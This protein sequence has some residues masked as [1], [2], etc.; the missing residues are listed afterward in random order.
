MTHI[1]KSALFKKYILS[2][3]LVF[4]LPLIVL[5]FAINFVYISSVREEL[6]LSNENYLEQSN[7]LLS[8][9][10]VEVKTLGNYIN[11][12][13]TF[14][15]FSSVMSENFNDY[16]ELIRHHEHSAS[17]I[18]ALYIVLDQSSYV[19]SSRG[20][21]TVPAML[22]H[23]IHFSNIEDMNKMYNMLDNSQESLFLL[24]DRLFYKMPLGT[25]PKAIGS[26]L[27]VMN[28][29]SIRSN[30]EM[31]YDRNE[32]MSFL[33]NNEGDIVLSSS[34]YPK[35]DQTSI[36]ANIPDLKEPG[37]MK[38]GRTDYLT[39]RVSNDLTGWSFISLIDSS[40]FYRPLYKALLLVILG[41]I[42]LTVFGL[43]ISYY[44]ANRNY[45]PVHKLVNAFDKEKKE[46][47]D[48]WGFL[49]QHISKT[50]TEVEAL[51]SLMDEQAPII[52]NA[53]LLDLL[54]GDFSSEHICEQRLLDSDIH[55]TYDYFST[56]I[57]EFGKSSAIP[58]Q[59][60]TVEKIARE[61]NNQLS[62][63]KYILEA[64]IP[65]LSNNQ[66]LLIVNLKN[67]NKL[68]WN[69]LIGEIR[70]YLSS[71]GFGEETVVKL[72]VG[73]TYSSYLKIRNSF[74]E[75][76][77][78]LEEL[79]KKRVKRTEILFF[80]DINR[81]EP[82]STV[83]RV[84]DY[85]KEMTLLLLQS[86]K[87]GNTKIAVE[88]IVELFSQ[89]RQKYSN[90][91][92]L[93]A[94]VSYVY[95]QVME[96]GNELNISKHNHLLFNL[97][98]FHDLDQAQEVLTQISHMLCEMVQEKKEYESNEIGNRI[99][100]HIFDEFLSPEIS[101]E[102]IAS[103][104]NISISYA[105]KIIKEETGDSFSNIIQSLRMNKFK[106]LLVTTT[107]PIKD[108]VVEVG[109]YDVS[110]FTRKFRKEH[111]LTPGQYRKKF[112]KTDLTAPA[113]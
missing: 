67:S 50:K 35:L 79:N 25:G 64:T 48:E 5:L 106:E 14:N 71:A 3:I 30:L 65:P 72:G 86:I 33:A 23:A 43:V 90:T 19:F 60:I 53:T 38:I 113:V 51:Y 34:V 9:Q 76:G 104:F 42:L 91:I 98:Q 52:K 77:A 10:V 68:I 78:A 102:Q 103:N 2:Y 62:N 88:T 96:T 21:M 8:E 66:I 17:S 110:N 58:D 84:I 55:F 45:K 80:S 83:N 28:T 74:V 37:V 22:N 11:Q 99:V 13:N 111:E 112:S 70:T 100:Q 108:L 39:N 81:L 101:L 93:Q 49:E 40:Q 6:T 73:T 20:N 95:N 94:S 56:V 63:E 4:S 69:S 1:P 87:Q 97:D 36:E 61:I 18:D 46:S 24:N 26:I 16:K 59:I 41:T 109:Y 92:A 54:E 107:L 44:F 105:S 82:D 57:I 7:L 27:V 47:E 75:A 12:T 29:H 15:R 32:G 31:L 85:P 89:I